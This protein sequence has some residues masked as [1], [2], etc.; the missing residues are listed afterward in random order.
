MSF[1]KSLKEVKRD[2]DV[3]KTDKNSVIKS[4]KGNRNLFKVLMVLRF[5]LDTSLV[6]T[7]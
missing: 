6:S 1:Y 4:Q 7:N 2:T 3:R 5:G